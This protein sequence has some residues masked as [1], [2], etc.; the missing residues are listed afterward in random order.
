MSCNLLRCTA[1]Y[2]K[3]LDGKRVL[4]KAGDVVHDDDPVVKGSEDHFVP[5]AD[6]V[7]VF[8]KRPAARKVAPVEQATAGPGEVRTKVGRPRKNGQKTEPAQA[9]EQSSPETEKKEDDDA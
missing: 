3:A 6:S 5:V 7:K 4:V 9:P 8:G 2:Y 1:A